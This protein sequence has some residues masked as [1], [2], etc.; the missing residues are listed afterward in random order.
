M[1]GTSPSVSNSLD[2]QAKKRSYSELKITGPPLYSQGE[3]TEN[4]MDYSLSR[5]R[6]PLEASRTA[7]L[8]VDVQ[9][10]KCTFVMV[11]IGAFLFLYS[12]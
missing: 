12:I 2:R 4:K 10:G 7:L 5:T 6:L 3:C 8:I 11:V 1:T 9:P